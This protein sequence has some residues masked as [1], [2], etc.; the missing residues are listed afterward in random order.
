MWFSTP[1][2]I[3]RE[4]PS[5]SCAVSRNPILSPTPSGRCSRGTTKSTAWSLYLC[6]RCGS[7]RFDLF[8]NGITVRFN[9]YFQSCIN[10]CAVWFDWFK[11]CVRLNSWVTFPH[12][13]CTLRRLWMRKL[14]LAAT[15][16]WR[17]LSSR[18]KEKIKRRREKW[19]PSL[20]VSACCVLKY[21]QRLH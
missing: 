7:D 13:C 2:R 14:L 18:R 19:T 20:L 9:E 3:S 5:L 11:K 17:G 15:W 16:T 21:A 1:A 12:R 8:C 6:N 10:F 4:K